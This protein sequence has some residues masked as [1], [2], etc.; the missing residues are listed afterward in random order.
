MAQRALSVSLGR[1]LLSSFVPNVRGPELGVPFWPVLLSEVTGE[2]VNHCP[3]DPRNA[4]ASATRSSNGIVAFSLEPRQR[5][6]SR[7]DL[8]SGTCKRVRIASGNESW[9]N[10][11]VS[12]SLGSTPTPST[13]LRCTSS[14]VASLHSPPPGTSNWQTRFSV[15]SGRESN[16]FIAAESLRGLR[17]GRGG[18]GEERETRCSS[19]EGDEDAIDFEHEACD[20]GRSRE[21]RELVRNK[22]YLSRIGTYS[23]KLLAKSAPF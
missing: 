11:A 15:Q 7:T 17:S 19:R 16:A 4:H 9:R 6:F 21:L 2:E 14:H 8:I 13:R 20:D 10:C 18:K 12:S 5:I 22:G 3:A 1:T 23:V